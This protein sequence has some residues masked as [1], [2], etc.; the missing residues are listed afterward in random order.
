MCL[1]VMAREKHERLQNKIA[2]IFS[3][4]KKSRAYIQLTNN[5]IKI[6]VPD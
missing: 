4:L 6:R 1:G 5:E 2:F 3:S